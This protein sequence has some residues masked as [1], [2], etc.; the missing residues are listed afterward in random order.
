MKGKAGYII[1]TV[2]IF[3]IGILVG[4]LAGGGLGK[5]KAVTL[6]NGQTLDARLADIDK[7]LGDIDKAILGG[8]GGLDQTKA[9]KTDVAGAPVL[10]NADAKVKIVLWS[11]FQ[12]P[13]CKN[14]AKALEDLVKTDTK[15]YGL[16]SKD[17]VVH[18]TAMLEHEAALAANAQGKYWEF[19]DL[20][21]ENQ[22]ELQQLSQNQDD[23]AY[24]AKLVELGQ[25][26]GLDTNKLK[27]ELDGHSYLAQIQKEIEEAKAMPINSTP[28]VLINEYFYG[29]DPA[30]IK[31]K[32]QELGEGKGGEA[33]SGTE[34][35]IKS[36]EK[37]LENLGKAIERKK[38]A[39]EGEQRGPKQG[40][41]YKFDLTKGPVVGE[42][43]A[44][45]K[46]AVF[47]DYMCPYCERMSGI[48]EGFQAEHPKDIA[49]FEKNFVVHP[50]AGIEH[51]AAM[52]AAAQGK[53]K[54]MHDLL[55]KNQ[56]EMQQ[57]GQQ[58]EDKLK[59]KIMALGKEAGLNVNQLKADLESGKYRDTIASD[60]KEGKEAGITGTPSVFVNGFFYGYNPEDIKKQIDEALKK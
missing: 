53:F 59:E 42:R 38:A 45:V 49:V 34:S 2:I 43:E 15:K 57:L 1:V 36:I 8:G 3:L 24:K 35:K 54:A 44:K 9:Y 29:F 18:P 27:T 23:T 37:H 52:S 47:S 6:S 14:M 31:A 60:M 11:D 48:L 26:A 5:N 12:C 4:D 32:A 20:L 17:L 33:V 22:P 58:G 21:F 39:A 28:T 19:H 41:E 56:Q 55:F 25:K 50:P 40:T 10:G 13:F 46:I 16:F 51:E 30:E 7:R